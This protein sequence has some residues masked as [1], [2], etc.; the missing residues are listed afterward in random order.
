MQQ[1]RLQLSP[2]PLLLVVEDVENVPHSQIPRST[3]EIINVFY[4][5][6]HFNNGRRLPFLKARADCELHDLITIPISYLWSSGLKVRQPPSL[7]PAV[8]IQAFCLCAFSYVRGTRL[9]AAGGYDSEIQS[10]GTKHISRL[11]CWI[12]TRPSF[13][14][15]CM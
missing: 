15:P 14:A 10:R 9:L 11:V 2:G 5:S 8:G 4:V 3:L 7:F 1:F 6:R 12:A 13:G